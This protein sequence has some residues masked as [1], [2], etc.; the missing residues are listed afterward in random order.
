MQTGSGSIESLTGD[1]LAA[2][3]VADD[4]DR[5]LNAQHEVEGLVVESPTEPTDEPPPPDRLGP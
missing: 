5:L 3:D 1:L 2:R 4:I